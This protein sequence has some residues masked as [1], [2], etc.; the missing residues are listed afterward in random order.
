[1]IVSIESTHDLA[2]W[3][4]AMGHEPQDTV[5]V[6]EVVESLLQGPPETWKKCRKCLKISPASNYD[7]NLANRGGLKHECKGCRRKH[8]NAYSRRVRVGEKIPAADL[9]EIQ[10]VRATQGL[11]PLP[12]GP[13]APKRG[14]PSKEK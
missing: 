10:R 11:E 5:T 13:D 8:N 9:A 7:A 1:M 6:A 2:K 3:I 12:F 4:Q 14:R